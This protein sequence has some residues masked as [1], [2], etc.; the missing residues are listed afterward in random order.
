MNNVLGG[1][2]RLRQRLFGSFLI[3]IALCLG[4]IITYTQLAPFGQIEDAPSFIGQQYA[5]QFAP[6]F[7]AS[8]ESTQNWDQAKAL[9]HLLVENR[10]RDLISEGALGPL[11]LIELRQ[12]FLIERIVLLDST[13]GVVADTLADPTSVKT[14]Q[15][16]MV[17]LIDERG[18]QIGSLIVVSGFNTDFLINLRKGA[19]RAVSGVT[20]W[21][22]LA[23]SIISI[24][25]SY[26]LT[27]PLQKL[28]QAAATLAEAG[29]VEKIPV[30]RR[31]EVGEL[32]VSFNEMVDRIQHQRQLR[33]QMVADIAHELRTP[34]SIIRLELSSVADGLQDPTVA[35]VSMQQE[36]DALEKLIGDLN[37][38]ALA[39]AHELKLNLREVDAVDFLTQAVRQWEQ[40]ARQSSMLIELKLPPRE[41][42]L[43]QADERRLYQILNNLVGN[44]LRYASASPT[45]EISLAVKDGGSVQ[46]S[47]RDFGPGIPPED[48]PHLFD[49]FYR[50]TQHEGSKTGGSGLGLAIAKRLVDL[51][52]GKIWC[53]SRLG[54]G[55]LFVVEFKSYEPP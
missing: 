39:D 37:L 4:L 30:T 21:A 50:V 38:L 49:R 22:A 13:G 19:R 1:K 33:Q 24:G 32:T 9:A 40:P 55:T 43:M 8:Y 28:S 41:E 20:L 14:L 17:P 51:H 11:E 46:F 6:I 53:E 16:I 48:I 45:L 10:A 7:G 15:P 52:A 12:A 2:V 42:I 26:R 5:I 25:L 44:A 29:D 23:S 34:L 54:E 31:D 3:V 36:L 18:I 35:T 27:R 47:V